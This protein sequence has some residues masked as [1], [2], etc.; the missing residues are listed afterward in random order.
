MILRRVPPVLSPVTPR[1]IL[2]AATAAVRP[3]QDDVE[4]L[5]RTLSATFDAPEVLLTDSGTSALVLALEAMSAPGGV[6]AIPGYACID[7]IAAAIRA[8]RPVML[9]DVDPD[10]L[11]P[12]LR[13][14][15]AVLERGAT[16]VVV[17]PLYGYPVDTGAVQALA[18]E[19]AV[20]LIEDAAQAAGS[21]L[22][23]KRVGSHGHVSVLS[24]GR[25]K[26]TTA[27]SGGALLVRRPSLLPWA[28]DEKR[29]LRATLR[30]HRNVVALGAQWL[31]GRP[32][33]YGIPASIPM[34]RLGEMV[35]HEAREPRHL[36][37]SAA[38]ALRVSL[39]LDDAEISCRRSHAT[40]LTA[41]MS[42][43]YRAIRP[44]PGAVP[45]YLR[46]A[47]RD[48]RADVTSTRVDLGVM[49]GYPITLDEHAATREVLMPDNVAIPGA[50]IL[51]DRLITIP[52]HSRVGPRDL[53]GL[54][55]WLGGASA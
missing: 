49:R 54:S 50:R 40:I 17:A 37:A 45:G 38:A 53:A 11:A 7:L 13:S 19:F 47:I 6:V 12:D 25:G 29:R 41:Q 28:R 8:R 33:L 5:E 24:F 10:T 18:D 55:A 36:S 4:S 27:G 20:A 23:G 39:T 3:T 16:A 26:G 9:Y 43:R 21:T 15:R 51:R 35:Y 44:V 30:D 31:L 48:L 22:G 14:L 1:T 34:L 46:L 42:G 2:R 32:S 52:T